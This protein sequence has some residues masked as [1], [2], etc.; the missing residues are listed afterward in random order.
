MWDV[1]RGMAGRGTWNG[2]D[3]IIRSPA[4]SVTTDARTQMWKAKMSLNCCK[5]WRTPKKVIFKLR[6]PSEELFR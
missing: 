5:I 4:S 6:P 2:N 3:H 1:G